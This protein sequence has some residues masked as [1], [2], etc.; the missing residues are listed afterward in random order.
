[1]VT[2]SLP[3]RNNIHNGEHE[4]GK[5][6]PEVLSITKRA[7]NV[8]FTSMSRISSFQE[9]PDVTITRPGAR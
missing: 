8:S 6:L 7:G 9:W 4:D 3:V 2:G 1:L 5:P